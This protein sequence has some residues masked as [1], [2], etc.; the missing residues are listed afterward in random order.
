[1]QCNISP[2]LLCLLTVMNTQHKLNVKRKARTGNYFNVSN[3]V[4]Q[5]G[6]FS[7][8]L[9]GVYVDDLPQKRF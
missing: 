9:S 8:T 4:K 6:V 3:G 2:R 7:P 5:G 1:M